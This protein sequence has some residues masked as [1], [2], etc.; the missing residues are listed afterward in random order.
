M[1]SITVSGNNTSAPVKILSESVIDAINSSGDEARFESS[2]AV[3]KTV[4]VPDSIN[5]KLTTAM[6]LIP[7]YGKTDGVPITS[8]T[9]SEPSSTTY[10]TTG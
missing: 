6:T 8:T 4:R 10:W 9:S 7:T 1:A 3:V 5:S 2:L